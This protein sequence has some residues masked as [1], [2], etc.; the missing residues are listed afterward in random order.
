MQKK[1]L[2][3][4]L[5][6]LTAVLAFSTQAKT[7]FSDAQ[8]AKVYRQAS[9]QMI[10]HNMG[11]IQ[12]MLQGKTAYDAAR[13]EKRADAL[14]LLT[15]MP[16]EAFDTPN[17]KAHPGNTKPAYFNSQAELDPMIAKFT[18]DAREL[19]SQAQAKDEAGVRRAFGQFARNCKACHD[20][21]KN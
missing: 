3:A 2:C 7:A 4:T 9:F 13:V 14:V 20:K 8:E 1:T 17:A 16:W 19:L 21:F 18:A 15:T 12:E 10:R 5:L 11:D 6:A